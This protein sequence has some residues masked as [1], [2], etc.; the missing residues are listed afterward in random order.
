MV[1]HLDVSL[2]LIVTCSRPASSSGIANTRL[3]LA[4][5]SSRRG[6]EDGYHAPIIMTP[7]NENLCHERDAPRANCLWLRLLLHHSAYQPGLSGSIS[8]TLP[9]N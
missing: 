9:W 8:G 4:N 6:R 2:R 1:Q 3:D 5:K 7:G